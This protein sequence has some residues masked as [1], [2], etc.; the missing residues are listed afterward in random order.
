MAAKAARDAHERASRPHPR[1]ERGDF[2]SG[3]TPD[4]F[5]RRTTMDVGVCRR[6]E[7]VQQSYVWSRGRDGS[8]SISRCLHAAAWGNDDVRSQMQEQG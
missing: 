3:V 4:L 1:N 8:G 2:A 5:R 7:L 6:L